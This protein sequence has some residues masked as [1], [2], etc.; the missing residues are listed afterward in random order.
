VYGK[1]VNNFDTSRPFGTIS[2]ETALVYS[3]N[4]VFCNIGLKLGAKAILDTAKRFGFY[5]RPPLETPADERQP[6]GLYQDG[7]LYYPRLDSDVDAGRMAF[8]QERLLVTPLQMA[9]VAGAIGVNGRLMEPQVVARIVAPDGRVV[10][11]QRP[12]LIRQAV[13][14]DTAASVARMMRLAVERGTGT[15]A[16]IPGWS[17]GGKTGTGETGVPGSNTTWFI[18]FAS[19]DEESPAELAVAVVLE[20]QAGTGGTTAAPIARAVMEAILQGTENP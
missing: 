16:Q 11:R 8:G 6:S 4:S 18:A 10:R 20:D 1:R 7:R 17:V 5:E 9:M 3:V 14:E 2:L 15:A 12:V 13:S 19:R